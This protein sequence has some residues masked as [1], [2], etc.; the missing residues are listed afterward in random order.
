[1]NK[2]INI[3]TPIGNN[4]GTELSWQEHEVISITEN[5]NNDIVPFEI[6]TC[7]GKYIPSSAFDGYW[8][9]FPHYGG[10]EWV[11]ELIEKT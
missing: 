7:C 10:W 4:F 5:P 9:H 8:S 2:K 11:D 6:K 3:G 1:M